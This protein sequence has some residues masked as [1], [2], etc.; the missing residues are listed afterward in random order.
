MNRSELDRLMVLAEVSRSLTSELDLSDIIHEILQ[1]ATRVIPAADA[2]MLFL[3]DSKRRR[4]A[5]NHAVG[6]GP[7]IYNLTVETGEGLS[8]KAFKSGRPAI[9]ADREAVMAGMV[10]SKQANLRRFTTAAAGLSFPQSAMAAP[11]MYKG[12]AL[13]ALVVENLY[14]PMV[15]GQFDI[16]LLEALAQVAAIAIVNARLFE[17]EREARLKLVALNEQARREHDEL[18][19]RLDVQDSFSAFVREGLPLASL[20][21]RLSTICK[22]E[23]VILDSLERVR[24]AEPPVTER[25]ARELYLASWQ[26]VRPALDQARRTLVPQELTLGQKQL[27][28]SPISGL[29]ELLGF[30]L[31]VCDGRAQS[32]VR[33]A[34]D[35]A[36]LIA[37]AAFL[38]ERAVEEANLRRSEDL[39]EQLLNGG[40]PIRPSFHGP[41]PPLILSVGAPWSGQPADAEQS[42]S[43]IQRAFLELTREAF[44]LNRIS[45]T[46]TA[47]DQYVAVLASSPLGHEL[48]AEVLEGVA[49]ALQELNRDWT[50]TWAISDPLPSFAEVRPIYFESRVALHVHQRL[51]RQGVVFHVASLRAYR[52]IL[53]AT[54]E[55]EAV[56][57]CE[58]ILGKVVQADDRRG[59][60]ILETFR[61]YLSLGH[62]VTATAKALSIHPH[63]VQY[64]LHRL[65]RL[66][67]LDLKQSEDR[68]T[69]ELAMR[70]L[71][72]ASVPTP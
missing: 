49:A 26:Q 60:N 20:A 51:K 44:D 58:Q 48:L 47:R 23:T 4:L 15:F 55:L 34:A 24:A 22:T 56:H 5:V 30:I 57:L 38:K 67:S 33:H 12:E 52:L 69:L 54:T 68:L 1:D 21:T 32:S 46:I 25:V 53:H 28:I 66:T 10:D 31:L 19:K 18:Q 71:D 70:I 6:F 41:E 3:Y 27:L 7:E 13:G 14:T 36:G 62:R 40:T 9:Y 61:T 50:A 17:S 72:L 45:A 8:G 59:G 42:E 16:S 65:E 2:G 43:G 39:L 37:A 63:T 64:R 11:L 29:G 35:S